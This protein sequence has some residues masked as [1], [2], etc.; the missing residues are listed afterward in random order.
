M[1]EGRQTFP[2]G[3]RGVV[4]PRAKPAPAIRSAVKAALRW[5]PRTRFF[6]QAHDFV[7]F[8]YAHR[9]LPWRDSGLFNDYLYFL[10]TFQQAF[11]VF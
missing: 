1:T 9:R 3:A 5:L 10:K 8:V 4:A 2:G 7:F 11:P 6:D